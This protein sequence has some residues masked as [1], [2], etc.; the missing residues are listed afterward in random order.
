M[1]GETPAAP[2]PEA[3]ILG[4]LLVIQ[5]TLDMMPDV[6]RMASFLRSALGQLPGVRE[7]CLCVASG[8]LPVR[9][10]SDADDAD[11][12]NAS[13]VRAP[14]DGQPETHSILLRRARQIYG[15]LVLELS[16]R[17]AFAPYAAFLGRPVEVRW[18]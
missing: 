14:S 13:E 17:R 3:A 5:Q 1:M 15:V 2:G 7:A 16:D 10:N 4:R 6:D 12:S 11:D 18:Q 8:V 9:A